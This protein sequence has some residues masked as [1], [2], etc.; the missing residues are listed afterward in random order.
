[1]IPLKIHRR[2]TVI[3]KAGIAQLVERN[4]AKVDVAGSSPVSRS[5]I[6]KSPRITLISTH[7]IFCNLIFHKTNSCRSVR[8]CGRGFYL[9][10]YPSGLRE[11]SAKLRFGGSNP[12]D[13]SI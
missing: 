5:L 8:I 7:N 2:I 13:T 9:V 6:L 12:P 11:K 4:L 3:A 1:M 10:S